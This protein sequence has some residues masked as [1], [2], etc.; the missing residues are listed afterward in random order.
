M[1]RTP[2]TTTNGSK[3]SVFNWS[4]FLFISWWSYRAFACADSALITDC[5]QRGLLPAMQ[6]HK[7]MGKAMFL[8]PET[9]PVEE[10]KPISHVPIPWK[11]LGM[12]KGFRGQP[13]TRLVIPLQK[14]S[15]ICNSSR[16]SL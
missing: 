5:E 13:G 7:S 14:P 1:F 10:S 12:V 6:L 8:T 9:S 16:A 4:L 2:S 11:T 15:C 3:F